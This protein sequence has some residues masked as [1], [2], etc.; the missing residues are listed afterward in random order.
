MGSPEQ[1]LACQRRGSE[2]KVIDTLTLGG[3]LGSETLVDSPGPS[4]RRCGKVLIPRMC[5]NA[6][7]SR[8]DVVGHQ[9][10]P[11]LSPFGCA[12]DADDVTSN[13][14]CCTT[15]SCFVPIVVP[16]CDAKTLVTLGIPP[17]ITN[18]RSARAS[19]RGMGWK[20]RGTAHVS[21]VAPT[22]LMPLQRSLSL[23]HVT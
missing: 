11:T 19:T 5:K 1:K 2:A 8:W 6:K 7:S 9:V 22:I 12:C 14:S 23:K 15:Y 3:V 10:L 16:P 21:F 20:S 18:E 17:R 13:V 4:A